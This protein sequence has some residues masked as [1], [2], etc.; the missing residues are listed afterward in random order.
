MTFYGYFD[1]ESIWVLV[2]LIGKRKGTWGCKE[3]EKREGKE[4]ERMIRIKVSKPQY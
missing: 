2:V 4:R 1:R 3:K